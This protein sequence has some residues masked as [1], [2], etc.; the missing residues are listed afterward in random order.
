MSRNSAS[1]DEVVN[2]DANESND[3][4]VMLIDAWTFTTL[5]TSGR[6]G[7]ASTDGY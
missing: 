3:E 6:D 4:D 5:G 1:D 2:A 7:P